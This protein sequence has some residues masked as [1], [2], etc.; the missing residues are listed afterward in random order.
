M[1]GKRGIVRGRGHVLAY[2][3]QNKSA[4]LDCL[5]KMKMNEKRAVKN[6]FDRKS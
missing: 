3:K 5:E 4:T 2:A 6:V 1:A